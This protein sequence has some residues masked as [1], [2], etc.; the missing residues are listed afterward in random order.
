MSVIRRVIVVGA[1]AGFSIGSQIQLTL[2]QSRGPTVELARTALD[3]TS[4]Q[5]IAFRNYDGRQWIY[6]TGIVTWHCALKQVLYSINSEALDQVFPLPEC[7]EQT[8]YS[9]DPER[10][11]VYVN[12]KLGSAETVAVQIVF[13]DGTKSEI[14][15]YQPC[16]VE[17]DVTCAVPVKP[18]EEN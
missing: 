2:A 5:W 4:D 16:K 17:G 13:A 8:P 1:L 18:D 15:S 6:F 14:N 9:V 10:D 12:M 7:N 3:A 11:P